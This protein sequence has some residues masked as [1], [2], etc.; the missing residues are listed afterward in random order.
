MEQK[1]ITTKE[2]ITKLLE[3]DPNGSREIVLDVPGTDDWNYE[4]YEDDIGVSYFYNQIIIT[5]PLGR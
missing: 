4:V 2:L 5:I 3:L 1:C